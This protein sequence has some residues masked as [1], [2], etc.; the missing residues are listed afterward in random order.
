MEQEFRVFILQGF[1]DRRDQREEAQRRKGVQREN[2]QDDHHLSLFFAK[3]KS[4]FLCGKLMLH[5]RFFFAD[6][7]SQPV[8]CNGLEAFAK[9]REFL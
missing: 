2:L 3:T 5:P 7:V 6:V 9:K 1:V 4:N 8:S